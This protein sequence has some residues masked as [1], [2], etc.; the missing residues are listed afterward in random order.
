MA[1][2]VIPTMW[3]WPDGIRIFLPHGLNETH[4]F[5]TKSKVF[6]EIISRNIGA[7]LRF[8]INQYFASTID[9]NRA[10]NAACEGLAA[11]SNSGAGCLHQVKIGGERR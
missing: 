5:E 7:L 9:G 3:G 11:S 2:E 4:V 10:I 6:A 8:R 1:I